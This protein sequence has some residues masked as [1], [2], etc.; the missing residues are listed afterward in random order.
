MQIK[1]TELLFSKGANASFTVLPVIKAAKDPKDLKQ[2]TSAHPAAK[3]NPI[4][5]NAFLDGV[6]DGLLES[7]L[8]SEFSPFASTGSRDSLEDGFWYAPISK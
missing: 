2:T 7:S 8:G 4:V 3:L 6:H 1:Y 5:S